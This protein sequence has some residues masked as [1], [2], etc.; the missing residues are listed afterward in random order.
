MVAGGAFTQ[1]LPHAK[2][3]PPLD[4]EWIQEPLRARCRPRPAIVEARSLG[5][6]SAALFDGICGNAHPIVF[7]P[8]A[9]EKPP[10]S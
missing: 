3:N 10:Q 4:E 5:A 7:C 9:S 2:A 1:S 8:T 6:G